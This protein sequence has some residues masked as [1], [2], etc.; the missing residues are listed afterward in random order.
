MKVV[1]LDYVAEIIQD[2]SFGEALLRKNGI[3]L[4]YA[5]C[6]TEDEMIRQG[7]DADGILYIGINKLTR[8]VIEQLVNCKV[9]VRYGIGY[10]AVDIDAA[11]DMGIAVCNIPHYCTEEVATHAIAL[12][13]DCLRSVTSLSNKVKQ[14][15]WDNIPHEVTHRLSTLTVGLAGFGNIPRQVAKSLRGFD[16]KLISYD[17][18]QADSVFREYGVE[19]VTLDELCRRSDILS[20]HVPLDENTYHLFNRDTFDL[21]KNG[22]ILINTSRGPLINEADLVDAL[23]SGKV[24]AAGLDVTESDPQKEPNARI[25]R[26]DHVTLTPHTAFDSV[27]SSALLKQLFCESA[28]QVLG[29]ALPN[30]VVNKDSLI[31]RKIKNDGKCCS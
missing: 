24:R 22:V 4:V 15:N 10:D 7:H 20:V 3:D 16:C 6:K 5:A 31:N 23:G 26:F 13:L 1:F 8:R 11:T 17:P 28:I 18:F 30:N 21:M 14:G 27:E 2:F 12:M 19:R 25:L 9:I 29:G